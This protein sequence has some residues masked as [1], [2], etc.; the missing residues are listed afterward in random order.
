MYAD[1]LLIPWFECLR[2]ELDALDVYDC[3]THVG[4]NDPSGFSATF[5]ELVEALE[6]IDGRAAVFPLKEPAG[7]REANLRLIEAAA[8]TGDLLVAFARLDPADAPALRAQEALEA[9]A[10]GLKLH[11]AG[12]EFDLSDPRLAD[13]W[14]L[15]DHE[16]LPVMV[17]AGPELETVGETVLEIASTHPGARLIVAH[18]AIIDFAWLWREVAAFPN[19]FLDTSWWSPTDVLAVL[20]LVP[21]GHVLSAS[22][23]P[24]CT[25]L[26]GALSTIR[27]ALELGLSR[28]EI[29]PVLG[30]QF[31]RLLRRDDPVFPEASPQRIHAP[32]D[33]L[34]ER[35]YVYLTAA[36]EPMQRGGDPEQM[37]VLARHATQV[38]ADHPQAE[39]MRSIQELLDL[40]ERHRDGLQ[41]SNQYAPGWDLIAAGALIAR[42]PAAP[43]PAPVVG[44][45][46]S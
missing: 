17:H 38:P 34:L 43:V 1:E 26:S 28:E 36:L 46:R 19:L 22:D 23:L 5:G 24:Y 21:A 39:S 35:V 6:F 40:Y 27:C 33:P 2:Q 9:G 15:A 25:P 41:T 10:R 44:R 30:G 32:L 37:L 16:R 42:T 7:Y 8:E 13:V 14:E 20:S 12:E 29:A 45:T 31:E 18:A 3:H 4:V 11:P